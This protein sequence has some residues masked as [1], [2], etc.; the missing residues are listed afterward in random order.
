AVLREF[1]SATMDEDVHFFG[2]QPRSRR[3]E[4]AV[5]NYRLLGDRHLIT[6]NEPNGL[7]LVYYLKEQPKEKVT[8]MVAAAGGATVGT[9]EG[10]TK[11]GINRVVLEF[12]GFNRQ[13]PPEG[14]FQPRPPGEVREIPPGEYEVVLKV[15]ERKLTQTAR[16]LP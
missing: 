3:N 5:G 7:T 15:G 4:G 2:V 14:G 10:T 11:P 13:Q 8:I 9:L 12:G 16:V 1:S 6:P